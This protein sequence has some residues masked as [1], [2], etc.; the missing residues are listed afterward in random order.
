MFFIPGI[1]ALIYAGYDYA[2]DSWRIAE[3]SNVTSDGPPVYH[4]KTVIPI[5]GTL[6]M[7]QGLAEIARCIVCLR[8]GVWPSRLHDVQEMDVANA[9]IVQSDDSPEGAR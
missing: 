7:I 9:Q 4:F 2:S 8:T 3:H 5:A 6:V 1:A